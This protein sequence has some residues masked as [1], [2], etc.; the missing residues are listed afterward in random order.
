[1]VSTTSSSSSFY[2]SVK[3]FLLV[4]KPNLKF[5]NPCSFIVMI[6]FL[7]YH[8]DLSLVP[9]P[10]S[11]SFSWK[12]TYIKINSFLEPWGDSPRTLEG[13][14]WNA[15]KKSFGTLEG[16]SWKSGI[17][18][19]PW[20]RESFLILLCSS[21]FSVY[22]LLLHFWQIVTD[23]RFWKVCKSCYPAALPIYF[24]RL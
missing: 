17:I 23:R 11:S 19:T 9:F 22:I 14:S 7:S 4:L 16:F 24:Q 5:I 20:T 13:L 1:M 18:N 3:G 8:L 6:F 12:V 21:G 10:H 2:E 15:E